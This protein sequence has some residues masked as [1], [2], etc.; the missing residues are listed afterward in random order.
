MSSRLIAALAAAWLALPAGAVGAAGAP[1]VTS[2]ED[3]CPPTEAFYR[4]FPDSIEYR[5]RV[6]LT[7]CA[8]YDGGPAV[9]SGS[10]TRTGLLGR[11]TAE[12]TVRCEPAAPPLAHD[13]DRHGPGYLDLPAGPPVPEPQ[14]EPPPAHRHDEEVRPVDNCVL[15]LRMDHLA[16]EHA[17]YE[18]ELRYPGPG[19]EQIERM[20]IEC[21]SLYEASGCADAS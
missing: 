10:M 7:G 5:V 2:V 15:S 1:P 12:R 8:W 6:F 14:L 16:V 20:A 4:Y 3:P 13:H 17:R 19:G 11:Q 9:L 21:T 18:G